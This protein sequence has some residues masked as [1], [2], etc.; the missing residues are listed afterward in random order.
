MTRIAILAVSAAALAASGCSAKNPV[1][2]GTYTSHEAPHAD[3]RLTV[4][5]NKESV[6]FAMPGGG[7]V[8]RK[9]VA[10][11][12]SKWPTLCPRGMQ[13]TS[14]EVLDLGDAPLELAGTR[15]ERPVLVA[16]CLHKPILELMSRDAG[17]EI[18]KPEIVAFER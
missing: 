6:T 15:I 1:E 3:I 14:S 17:G 13:D 4:D 7:E 12:A 10:W 11:E 18:V 8:K 9:A 5:S 16:N 2:P